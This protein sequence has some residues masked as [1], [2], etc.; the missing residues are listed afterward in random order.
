VSS[1]LAHKPYG[2]IGAD[3]INGAVLGHRRGPDATHGLERSS[4][5][6]SASNTPARPDRPSVSGSHHHGRGRAPPLAHGCRVAWNDRQSIPVAPLSRRH[7]EAVAQPPGPHCLGRRLGHGFR[8]LEIAERQLHR[9]ELGEEIGGQEPLADV[10]HHLGHR[11]PLMA[12]YVRSCPG[13]SRNSPPWPKPLI[14]Q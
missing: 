12:A 5:R 3:R 4:E 7:H 13:R 6:L 8:L 1:P 14:E 10:S 2:L 9:A 11:K